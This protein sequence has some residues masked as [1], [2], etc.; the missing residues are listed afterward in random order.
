MSVKMLYNFFLT[1][2]IA[3]I[4]L[5]NSVSGQIVIAEETARGEYENGIFTAGKPEFRYRFEIDIKSGKAKL[6]EITRL[7]TGTLISQDV[8]YV[9]TAIEDSFAS[10][11]FLRSKNKKDEK[12]L[13]LVG[14]PGTLATEVILIGE[15][16]F[17]YC[18]AS[19]GRLYLATGKIKK[20]T[21]ATD[22][23]IEQFKK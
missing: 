10:S 2:C 5:Q 3:F 6:T 7:E 11:S 16:F 19:S 9:I 1:T 13:T 23:L 18:K 21:L 17:E 14:K 15:S 12:V 4:C 22:E 20:S 8:S